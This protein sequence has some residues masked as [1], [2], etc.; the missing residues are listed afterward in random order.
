MPHL[1]GGS[2][3][4]E[5]GDEIAISGGHWVLVELRDAVPRVPRVQLVNAAVALALLTRMSM[6]PKMACSVRSSK[7]PAA[8]FP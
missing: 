6:P 7:N 8:A 5:V 4:E 3:D 1:F 2:V